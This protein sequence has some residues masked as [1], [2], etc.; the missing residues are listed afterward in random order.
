MK[1]IIQKKFDTKNE[2]EADFSEKK[3]INN[4][5]ETNYH[6]KTSSKNW[7]EKRFQ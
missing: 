3:A 4:K 5:S 6:Q 7:D 1:Q 2:S